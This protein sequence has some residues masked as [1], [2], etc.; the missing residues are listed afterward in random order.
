MRVVRVLRR[1]YRKTP[2]IQCVD[3]RCLLSMTDDSTRCTLKPFKRAYRPPW[4]SSI[5]L[6][7]KITERKT[8]ERGQHLGIPPLSFAPLTFG[9]YCRTVVSVMSFLFLFYCPPILKMSLQRNIWRL[10]S[11]S[12]APSILSQLFDIDDPLVKQISP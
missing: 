2:F 8:D 4:P 11:R 5:I 10:Q 7:A 3:V 6:K 9:T 12:Y 1:P